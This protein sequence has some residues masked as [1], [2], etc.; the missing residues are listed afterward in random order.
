VVKYGMHRKEQSRKWKEDRW[1]TENWEYHGKERY[2]VCPNGRQLVYVET[3]EKRT[4]AGYKIRVD[5]YECASCKYCRLKKQCAR[6]KGNRAIERNE[7]W[8]RLK[9]K[10]K[11]TLQDE[12]YTPLEKQRSAEVETVFGQLKGNQGF[13]RFLLRGTAK[14]STE[15]GLLVLG[16]NVKQLHRIN[17]QKPA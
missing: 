4:H 5:R 13:R 2:Y 15:W 9:R 10:A 16:Y 3:R 17:N 7:R 11:K 12:R 8:L 14:V 6:A 1:N